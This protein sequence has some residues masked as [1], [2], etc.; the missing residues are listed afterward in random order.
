MWNQAFPRDHM[1]SDAQVFFR[2]FTFF[3]FKFRAAL[4]EIVQNR[5]NI[6]QPN[7]SGCWHCGEDGHFA[8][9]CPIGISLA[10]LMRRGE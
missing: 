1:L 4:G 9:S 8:K 7:L 6:G 2:F 10:A 5:H 3:D